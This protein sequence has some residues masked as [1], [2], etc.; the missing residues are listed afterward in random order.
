MSTTAFATNFAKNY[1]IVTT[2]GLTLGNIGSYITEGRTLSPYETIKIA[3]ES[4]PFSFS[5]VTIAG[6]LGTLANPILET[7]GIKQETPIRTAIASRVFYDAA[8]HFT[9]GFGSDI[10]TQAYKNIVG[11]QKGIDI[12]EALMVGTFTGGISLGISGIQALR[13][14]AGYVQS[15]GYYPYDIT[16]TSLTS[17]I[18]KGGTIQ[19]QIEGS[20]LVNRAY[21]K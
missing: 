18:K 9:A 4:I 21:P 1:A 17:S 12:K 8:T 15:F 14:P 11:W 19:A 20:G 6:R 16:V 13:N 10:A 3:T 2:A 5:Y 7:I